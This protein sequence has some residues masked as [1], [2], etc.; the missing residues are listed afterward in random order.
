MPSSGHRR[1]GMLSMREAQVEL[2][3]TSLPENAYHPLKA[4]EVYTPIVQAGTRTPEVTW[5]A[6]LWGALF[7]AV[8]TVASAYSTLKV[9]QGM[10]AAIP[11]SIL[12]IALA[13]IYKRRSS[14]LENVITIGIG[15]A[16]AAVVAGAVFTV[17]ALYILHLNPHPIQTVF[18]CLACEP[19]FSPVTSTSVMAVASGNGNCPCISRTK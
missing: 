17:P 18:I 3:K 6:V 16:S 14:L 4:G 5:R 7:C 13:R 9:G 19:P 1:W 12:A 11:I 8:F 15:G 10:E 2:D